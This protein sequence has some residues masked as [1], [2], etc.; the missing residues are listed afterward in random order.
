MA[1]KFSGRWSSSRYPGN[2]YGTAIANVNFPDQTVELALTYKG[3]FLNGVTRKFDFRLPELSQ[4][5]PFT[6]ITQGRSGDPL[7]NQQIVLIVDSLSEDV[8]SGSY[9]TES[10]KDEGEFLFYQGNSDPSNSQC[11]IL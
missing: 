9:K 8:F 7:K 5:Y 6:I 11:I 2:V 10:P 1:K 4:R 3:S